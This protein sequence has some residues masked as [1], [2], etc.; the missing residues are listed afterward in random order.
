[1]E[2][3]NPN[4]VVCPSHV[5]WSMLSASTTLVHLPLTFIDIHKPYTYCVN[6]F[7]DFDHFFELGHHLEKLKIHYV[8]PKNMKIPQLSAPFSFTGPENPV[9][10]LVP[11]NFKAPKRYTSSHGRWWQILP[12]PWEPSCDEVYRMIYGIWWGYTTAKTIWTPLLKQTSQAEELVNIN[13]V[14][15]CFVLLRFFWAGCCQID[16]SPT[17][18]GTYPKVGK[19]GCLQGGPVQ[20]TFC[21]HRHDQGNLQIRRPFIN[22]QF[23]ISLGWVMVLLIFSSQ[24]KTYIYILI[25]FW[26]DLNP[27]RPEH[28]LRCEVGQGSK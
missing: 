10:H 8:C 24:K 15:F 25:Y 9:G 5:W 28:H 26:Y 13:P 2:W 7:C 6:Q 20:I 4:K 16:R 3:S 21:T 12:Q 17:P 11:Y 23:S 22:W 1:M 14:L 19:M 18:N 27:R